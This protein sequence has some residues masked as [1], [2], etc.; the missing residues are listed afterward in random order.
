MHNR[1]K[2]I[3][4]LGFRSGFRLQFSFGLKPKFFRSSF[5]LP[6]KNDS[7]ENMI[8]NRIKFKLIVFSNIK[9]LLYERMFRK[10]LRINYEI[11]EYIY[12]I[13]YQKL[14]KRCSKRRVYETYSEKLEYISSKLFHTKH[15][16]LIKLSIICQENVSLNKKIISFRKKKMIS[17]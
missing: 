7:I 4:L 5:R 10:N 2:P 17:N 8:F 12:H 9:I 14:Y 6:S 16:H 11:L 13:Q 3:F 15:F 1:N